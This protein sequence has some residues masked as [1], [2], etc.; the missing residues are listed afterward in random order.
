MI[1]VFYPLEIY[2]VTFSNLRF[3]SS[4]YYCTSNA[5]I[6]S[7][8]VDSKRRIATNDRKEKREASRR[9]GIKSSAERRGGGWQPRDGSYAP[10][11]WLCRV[12]GAVIG[13]NFCG[14]ANRIRRRCV[15]V[16]SGTSGGLRAR[17]EGRPGARTESPRGNNRRELLTGAVVHAP[18]AHLD[19]RNKSARGEKGEAR[20]TRSYLRKSTST[21]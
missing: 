6:F 9:R 5:H 19:R 4:F 14:P 15:C 17:G 1:R 20:R 3:D 2:V 21:S 12:A 13:Y 7:P 16:T 10:V 11:V 18:L 8:N